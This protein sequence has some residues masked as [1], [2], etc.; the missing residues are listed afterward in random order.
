MTRTKRS[1]STGRGLDWLIVKL[2][3]THHAERTGGEHH[4]RL[5]RERTPDLLDRIRIERRVCD[6]SRCEIVLV[7]VGSAPDT[8]NWTM[9]MDR[10]VGGQ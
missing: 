1:T 7:F 9:R 10:I 2:T 5:L 3:L 4:Q 6:R 8:E